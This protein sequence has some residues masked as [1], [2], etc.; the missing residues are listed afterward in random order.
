MS[1]NESMQER[2][3][4][5]KRE[6]EE[7]KKNADKKDMVKQLS[8]Q[9][10]ADTDFLKIAE[11]FQR[12]QQEKPE[13]VNAHTVKDTIYI[14]EDLYKAFS[15]LCVNRGDKKKYVNAALRDFVLKKYKEL[16]G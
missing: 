16:Q 9:E 1:K 6:K 8:H 12:M 14:E 15:A 13:S 7:A 3:E 4:R 5:L 11:E 2:M 10:E